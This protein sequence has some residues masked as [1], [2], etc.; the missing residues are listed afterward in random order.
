MRVL[1]AE[2]VTGGKVRPVGGE[3]DDLHLVVP[4]GGV[5]GIVQLVEHSG[6]LRVSGLRT[7][8][9]DTSDVLGWNL[10]QNGFEIFHEASIKRSL[11]SVTVHPLL[12]PANLLPERP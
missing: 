6:V 2:V 11:V 5:E 12:A 9:H 7:V 1:L 3:H 8:Q 4:G 10:I